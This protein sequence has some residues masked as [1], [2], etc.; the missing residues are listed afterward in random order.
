MFGQEIAGCEG[1]VGL[2]RFR[3]KDHRDK[4]YSTLKS[5]VQHLAFEGG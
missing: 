4:W 2:A 3:G 1:Q 5:S